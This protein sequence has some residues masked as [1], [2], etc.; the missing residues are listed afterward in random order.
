VVLPDP[1]GPT[2]PRIDA[3]R[4][5]VDRLGALAAGQRD[6]DVRAALFEV[7]TALVGPPAPDGD[8]PSPDVTSTPND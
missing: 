6:D 1:D 7:A 2:M 5:S 8:L 4:A 3:L